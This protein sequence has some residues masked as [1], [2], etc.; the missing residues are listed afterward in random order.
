M[1]FRAAVAAAGLL[2]AGLVLFVG[3]HGFFRGFAGDIGVV[4]FLVAC[5]AAVRV[6]TPRARLVGVGLV[7][8]GTEAFQGLHLV[9]PESHWLLHLTLGSTFD[10]WDL[11]A[12]ALGLIAAVFAERA[13]AS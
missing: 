11:L 2:A 9:G 8:L 3:A 5:L 12:Y 4:V 13:W 10:P 1:N 6:G 7:A